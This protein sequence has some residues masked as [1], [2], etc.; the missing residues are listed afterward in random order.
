MKSIHEIPLT[1]FH[2]DVDAFIF[3]NCQGFESIIVSPSN[4]FGLGSGPFNTRSQQIP[5]MI[6]ASLKYGY[7]GAIGKGINSWSHVHIEDLADFYFLLLEEALLG[8]ASTGKD[9]FYFVESGEDYRKD[10]TSK[11][12]EELF[13][14]HLIKQAE[15]VE[16][17]LDELETYF[18]GWDWTISSNCRVRADKAKELG[19]KPNAGRENIYD[20]IKGEVDVILA[21][22]KEKK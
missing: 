19:W 12:G 11:I 2:R 21:A 14:R 5:M 7:A 1:Q 8:K 6:K 16:Y 22:Q 13:K 20:S 15:P 10:I 4:I 9:G 17:K 3:D 18:G